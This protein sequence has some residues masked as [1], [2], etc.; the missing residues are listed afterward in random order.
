VSDDELI[1]TFEACRLEPAAFH[2]RDHVRLTH[3]YLQRFPT[4]DVLGRLSAGLAALARSAGK[5]DRYHETITW[6]N[7]FLIRERMIRS[8]RGQNWPE[9]AE[10]NADLLNW[11]DHVLR[12]YYRS[13]TL[14]S[15]IARRTFVMPDRI[16]D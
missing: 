8:A 7:V 15:P 12:R 16:V 5:P 10:N 6:A 3:A 2:H 13:A 11:K 1:E 9:F 4:L 14:D